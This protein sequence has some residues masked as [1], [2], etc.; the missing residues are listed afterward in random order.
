MNHAQAVD[1]SL[2]C[3]DLGFLCGWSSHGGDAADAVGG[4]TEHLREAHH[5]APG[6]LTVTEYLERH[7]HEARPDGR[8]QARGRPVGTHSAQTVFQRVAGSL[9]RE[10]EPDDETDGEN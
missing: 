7:V 10:I 6:S 4:I 3:V 1:Y 9:R 5:I 2:D 8:V